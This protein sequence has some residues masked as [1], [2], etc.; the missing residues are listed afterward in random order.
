MEPNV[1]FMA[2]AIEIAERGLARVSPNP[3]VGCVLVRDG[4]I[5]AEGWHDRIGTYTRS[6]Q[7]LQMPKNVENQQKDPQHTSH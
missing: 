7:Q 5:I 1:Q 3:P 2:R 6:R 4:R